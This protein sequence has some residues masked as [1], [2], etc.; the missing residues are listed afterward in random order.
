MR[1]LCLRAS[2]RP[3]QQSTSVRTTAEIAKNI[4]NFCIRRWA[5]EG[6]LGLGGK[7]RAATAEGGGL[8]LQK[9]AGCQGVAEAIAFR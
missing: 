3:S 2:K 9:T 7:R 5:V 8:P 1:K 6:K 4:P